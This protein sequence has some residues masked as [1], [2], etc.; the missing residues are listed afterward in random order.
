MALSA[1]IRR[2]DFASA[3]PHNRDV[4]TFALYLKRLY[5]T[6]FFALG[7]CASGNKE[8]WPEPQDQMAGFSKITPVAARKPSAIASGNLPSS[9]FDP[10]NPLGLADDAWLVVLLAHVDPGY[11]VERSPVKILMQTDWVKRVS[12]D[13]SA[14]PLARDPKEDYLIRSAGLELKSFYTVK[15][16]G[17]QGSR[18]DNAGSLPLDLSVLQPGEAAE[19]V[20]EVLREQPDG[21]TERLGTLRISADAIKSAL[22]A[23]KTGFLVTERLPLKYRGLASI[24][25]SVHCPAS[26]G[27]RD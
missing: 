4:P 24:Q 23:N 5:F 19:I 9:C 8:A 18:Y 15:M 20:A 7:A 22:A 2:I 3:R 10:K 25:S 14:R 6:V 13:G 27:V 11:A 16:P 21:N 1:S 17:E 12:S 26:H